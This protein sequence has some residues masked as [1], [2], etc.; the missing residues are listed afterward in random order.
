M[1]GQPLPLEDHAVRYCKR[2][3]VDDDG[4]VGPGAFMLRNLQ[5][6]RET[7]LSANWLE[8]LPGANEGERIVELRRVH[9]LQ[10]KERDLFALLRVGDT[11]EAVQTGSQTNK[12]LR[13][14]CEAAD[15][16]PDY[17]HAGIHDT[18]GPDEEDTAQLL[19]DAICRSYPAL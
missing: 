12:L 10:R 2:S 19:A 18:D 8:R 3:T 9:S 13:F 15:E 4:F 6:V 7:Y 17:S 1:R 16:E 11:I 5:G 14:L